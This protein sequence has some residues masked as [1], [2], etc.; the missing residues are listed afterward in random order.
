MVSHSNG[1]FLRPNYSAVIEIIIFQRRLNRLK[2][3][4]NEDHMHVQNIHGLLDPFTCL[5]HIW[6]FWSSHLSCF[7]VLLVL[8]PGLLF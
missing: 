1:D 6:L 3:G 8:L 4:H 7:G 2:T 5:K